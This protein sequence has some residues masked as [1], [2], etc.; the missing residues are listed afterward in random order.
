MC[1]TDQREY[2]NEKED[3]EDKDMDDG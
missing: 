3:K 2:G 1:G